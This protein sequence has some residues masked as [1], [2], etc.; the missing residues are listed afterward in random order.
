MP[1]H[2]PSSIDRLPPDILEQFQALLRDP[3]VTQLAA[4]AKIN[5]VLEAEGVPDRLS[6][7]AVNRY[8]VR[9]DE[10]GR[11]LRETREVAKMWIGELGSEPQGEVGKL[12]NEM[13]RTL[14]FRMAMRASEADDDEPIDPKLLKSLAISVYRLEKAASENMELEVKIKKQAKTQAADAVETA[15][16]KQGASAATIDMLRAAIM[17]EMSA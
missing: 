6:K 16:K 10:V 2:Q 3:R 4:T 7:S 14:A 1:K 15:A 13:V 9:M 11:K 12:L 17:E 8:S 5:A